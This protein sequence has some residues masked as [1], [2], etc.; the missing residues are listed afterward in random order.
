MPFIL[1]GDFQFPGEQL[2]E[3][4]W[5]GDLQADVVFDAAN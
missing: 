3:S 2:V 1:G 5:L 4:G